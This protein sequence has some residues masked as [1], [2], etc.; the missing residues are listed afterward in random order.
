MTL[1]PA[2]DRAYRKLYSAQSARQRRWRG[3]R[4][5][6][7][8]N[9]EAQLLFILVYQK[10]YPLQIVQGE[11]FGLSQ[12]Q[13]SYW[14]HHLLPVLQTALDTLGFKP[15]RE[16]AQFAKCERL[17][18]DRHDL[19]IDGTDRRRQRPKQ[20][21]K[22]ALHYSGRKK[23]HTDKNLV[24]VTR[25]SKRIAFLSSTQ[26]GTVSDQKMADQAH[27]VYPRG[28]RLRHDLGFQGYKPRVQQTDQPKKNRANAS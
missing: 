8:P 12:S 1:L 7:L 3:G 27:I 28:T 9:R 13:A 20:P 25:S 5:P 15:A 14:I 23:T 26:A 22:Q 24:V 2:F 21:A 11:L 18:Q 6:V 19:I 10:T 16:G 17:R 4:K